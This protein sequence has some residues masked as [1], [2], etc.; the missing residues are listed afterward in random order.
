MNKHGSKVVWSLNKKLL[1]LLL[2]VMLV[3]LAGCGSPAPED[4]AKVMELKLA[5]FFPSTHPVE[6]ELIQPWA[7]AVEEATNGQ[8]KITSYPGETLLKA[9]QVYDGVVS[10]VADIGM[11]CFSYTR[12][13][14]PVMEAFE[15]PGVVYNNSKVASNVAWEGIKQINP[16]EIQD[17]KMMMALTTGPGD[18]FTTVP[19]RSLEDIQGLAI[20]ATG[21]SAETLKKL[22]ANPV[23]MPQSDA[24]ESLSKGVVKGNLSPVEV[25]QGWKHAE[26]TKYLTR[27]PFLYNTLFFVTM[28]LDKWNSLS[29]EN[30]EAIEAVNEKYFK[31]VA[32]GLWDRQNEAALQWAVEEQGVHEIKLTGEETERWMK[33]VQPIQD[34]YVANLEAKGLDGR[35]V[36]DTVLNLADK[37]NQEYQ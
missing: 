7:R 18:L 11:S 26:V 37:Y 10:G 15:L 16:V 23:A 2:L 4:G 22:G 34:E 30:Q 5:H 25:L 9:D 14:F 27:T 24:Y 32:M 29:P 35:Q 1:G 36:M 21:L 33:L 31:E 6:T 3:F 19:V 17:T 12:G 20:R 13:R 28:N 8:V